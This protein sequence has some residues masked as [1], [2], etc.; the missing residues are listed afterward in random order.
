MVGIGRVRSAVNMHDL[1]GEPIRAPNHA[2]YQTI[3]QEYNNKISFL[4]E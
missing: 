3:P 1:T 2:S 4:C